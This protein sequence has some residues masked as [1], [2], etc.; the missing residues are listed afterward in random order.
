[1]SK[2]TLTLT[3]TMTFAV[4]WAATLCAQIQPPQPP[5][6]QAPPKMTATEAEAARAGA[7]FRQFSAWLEAFNA[8]DPTRIRQFLQTNFPSANVDVQMNFRERTGGLEL[9]ALEQ[10]TATMLTGLVQ[11]RDSDQFGRFTIVVEPAEPHRI[12]RFPIRAILPPA[13]F[14]ALRLSEPEV[15]TALRAKLDRDAAADRFAGTA[16]LAKNGKVLFSGGY[17]LADR[18]KKA[19]SNLD[20]R[21][22]IGSMNKMFTAVVILQLVQAGKI[23]LTDP[24]GKYVTH[25]PNQDVATRVTIHHLL[26][27]TGGTGDIFGPEFN[28]HRLELRTLDDYVALYGKRG[29]AF[30]PGSTGSTATMACCSLAW[31]SR[32]SAA[33]VTTI[34]W[35]TTSINPWE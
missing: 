10:A 22:R 30:E 16:L 12:T 7:P 29:L 14:A 21:F 6:E 19:A 27:H 33:E 4:L 5:P 11:E 35:R 18:E 1:M 15:I 31:W 13:E 28:A 26:T 8:G 23:K 25:Y 20:S 34:T 9:R 32:E 3:F 24:L 2:L 17:G